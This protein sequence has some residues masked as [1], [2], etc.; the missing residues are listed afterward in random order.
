MRDES[1]EQNGEDSVKSNF[2]N[3]SKY[4]DDVCEVIVCE[5][6]NFLKSSINSR[7][8]SAKLLF[9]NSNDDSTFIVGQMVS[10]THFRKTKQF[11]CFQFL[12]T[13]S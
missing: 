5:F 6:I 2:T 10:Q 4:T 8:E 7:C 1:S 9:Q 3:I 12:G 13:L 11:H